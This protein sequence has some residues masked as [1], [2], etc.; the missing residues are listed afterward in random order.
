MHWQLWLKA[1]YCCCVEIFSQFMCYYVFQSDETYYKMFTY[2][3][4]ILTAPGL[5]GRT[6]IYFQACISSTVNDKS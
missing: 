1:T 3:N 2:V 4:K 5:D 6:L